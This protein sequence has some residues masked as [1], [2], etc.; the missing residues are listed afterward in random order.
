[1]GGIPEGVQIFK[2]SSL[3]LSRAEQE[4]AG[5]ENTHLWHYILG[6]SDNSQLVSKTSSLSVLFT[7]LLIDCLKLEQ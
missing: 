7:Y 6:E 1:M 4:R 3:Y 5:Q 2:F